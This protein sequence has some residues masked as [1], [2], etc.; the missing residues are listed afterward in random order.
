MKRPVVHFTSSEPCRSDTI[1]TRTRLQIFL[2]LLVG[3]YHLSIKD[4]PKLELQVTRMKGNT[5]LGV[6][7]FS[8]EASITQ[9]LML[10]SAR[11][12]YGGPT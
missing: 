1:R 6:M 11:R 5:L 10:L 2:K 8:I 7:R 9:V 3:R 4:S 12:C